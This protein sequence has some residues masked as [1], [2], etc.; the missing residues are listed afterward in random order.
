MDSKTLYTQYEHAVI[1][2]HTASPWTYIPEEWLFDSDYMEAHRYVLRRTKDAKQG[3]LHPRVE[4]QIKEKLSW[5]EL[6]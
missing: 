1:R 5:L 3:K 2:K 6:T 4:E